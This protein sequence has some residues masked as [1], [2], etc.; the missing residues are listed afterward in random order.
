MVKGMLP[1]G[2]IDWEK[3]LLVT[4]A[5]SGCT[6]CGVLAA[7]ASGLMLEG[8]AGLLILAGSIESP[9]CQPS[10]PVDV[11]ELVASGPAGTDPLSACCFSVKQQSHHKCADKPRL[12]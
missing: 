1:G 3:L 4:V 11:T 9:V 12:R 10:A 6:A 2:G 8:L 5:G 7:C